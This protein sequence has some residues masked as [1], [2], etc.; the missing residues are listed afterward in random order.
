MIILAVNNVDWTQLVFLVLGGLGIFLY[1][2]HI[3][4]ESLKLLAGTKLK[5]MI[6]KTTNTPLKGIFVGI[7]ITG[8]LQSSSGTTA[9]TVGLVRAGLMTLPQAVG[10]ILGANIG[11]TVTSFLIGLEIKAYALP[12]MG[13]GCMLI[14]FMQSKKLTRVGGAMLGFGMIFYGLDLMGGALKVFVEFEAFELAMVRVSD[15]PVLGV[16]VGAVLTALVQSSTATIGILQ[17][18]YTTGKMPL[19]GAIA[20]VLGSNIGT[21]ITAIFAAIGGSVSAKRTAAAHVVFNV[22]GSVLFLLLIYPYFLWIRL[23]ENTFY[24]GQ[25]VAMTI[26]FAHI[27]FNIFNTFVMYW[28]IKYLVK[29]SVKIIPGD[30][31]MDT[32]KIGNLQDN[33]IKESPVLALENAKFVITGMGNIVK[34]MYD[35]SIR[36]AYEEDKKLLEEGR[37]LEE[38]VDTIDQK[39]HDYLVKVS[40]TDLDQDLAHLQAIYIDA[41]RDYERI[42]DHCQNLFDFFEHRYE[43]KKIMSKAAIKDIEHIFGIVE[44]TIAL[45]LEA[46]EEQNKLRAEQILELEDEI[47]ALVRKYRKRHVMRMN[48]CIQPECDD[49]LFVDILSNVERIGDHCTNIAVNVLQKN[50]YHDVDEKTQHPAMKPL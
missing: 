24:A 5:V 29:L 31:V 27:F 17:E 42:A 44:E 28:F 32:V 30:D 4:G 8:L 3:M 6:E 25:P 22:A 21:T 38:L 15:I 35:N 18:L 11:T 39:V 46:F 49:D 50:Y 47:D 14:F 43:T 23:L 19:I 36:Y 13:I 48:E 9:L 37:Q 26:S 7:V 40:L 41:I 16:I 1:G 33:L 12:I 10:I 45:T 2:I 34:K 20:I